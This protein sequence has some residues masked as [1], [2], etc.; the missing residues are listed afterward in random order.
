[1]PLERAGP[2]AVQ[3]RPSGNQELDLLRTHGPNLLASPARLFGF[4][5]GRE[6][7]GTLHWTLETFSHRK[8]DQWDLRQGT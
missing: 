6:F 5:L 3:Q 7:G 2:T 1:M 4:V 8:K